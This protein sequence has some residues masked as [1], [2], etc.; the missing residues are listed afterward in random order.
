[1]IIP[2]HLTPICLVPKL[3]TLVYIYINNEL[4]KYIIKLVW[5]TINT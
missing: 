4:N 2:G 1:M 3:T 5:Y